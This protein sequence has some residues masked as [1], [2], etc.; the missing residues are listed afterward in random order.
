MATFVTVTLKPY[1][2][3]GVSF[4]YLISGTGIECMVSGSNVFL[5]PFENDRFTGRL[6]S[7]VRHDRVVVEQTQRLILTVDED[8]IEDRSEKYSININIIWNIVHLTWHQYRMSE[9]TWGS[10]FWS[11]F[12]GTVA[13]SLFFQSPKQTLHIYIIYVPWR[14]DC[15][16]ELEV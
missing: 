9:K 2:I 14:V 4:Y 7:S 13:R 3:T 11:Q 16:C 6:T 8:R 12:H 1:F 5:A 10:S 15:Y